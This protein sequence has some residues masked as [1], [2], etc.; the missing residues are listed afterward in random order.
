M[1]NLVVNPYAR[2]GG[3]IKVYAPGT[4]TA[5]RTITDG[6]SSPAFFTVAG[7]GAL[8][9]PNQQAPPNASYVLEFAPNA[10]RAS[11]VIKGFEYPTGTAISPASN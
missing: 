2:P 9:I 10:A 4:T 5:F 6:L 1:S 7:N 8:F 11:F 3:G